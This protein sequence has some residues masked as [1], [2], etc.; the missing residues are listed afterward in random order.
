MSTYS[1]EI[2]G[3]YKLMDNRVVEHMG[4]INAGNETNIENKE[5]TKKAK[6]L[7]TKIDQSTLVKGMSEMLSSVLNEVAQQNQAEMAALIT[8]SNEME[9]SNVDLGDGVFEITDTTQT[10]EVNQTA[11]M[12]AKQK[13]ES[14]V[15]N[16]I[17]KSIDEALSKTVDK[18]KQD[19]STKD[20]KE[21]GGTNIG[22]VF[23]KDLGGKLIDGAK[24]ILSINAGNTTNTKNIKENE[25]KLKKTFNLDESFK[26][27]KDSKVE[28]A[29]KNILKKENLAKCVAKTGGKNAFRVDNLKAGGVKIKGFN[30]KAAIAQVLNC[31]FDQQALD[32]ISNLMVQSYSQLVDNMIKSSD[33]KAT[34][35]KR[36]ITS[37]D[38]YAAGVAGKQ[39]LVAGGKFAKD[40]GTGLATA[41]KG[42]GEGVGSVFSGFMKPLIII[43][44]IGAIGGIIMLVIK[45]SAKKGGRSGQSTPLLDSGSSGNDGFMD[46]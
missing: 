8:Y 9:F 18:L 41:A 44:I 40:A 32:D 30:Q 10:T 38:I 20:I 5:I 28:D 4:L 17:S 14:K 22:D 34:K 37:G 1:Y 2:D 27:E 26:I 3:S 11:N 39:I 23:G 16:S 7:D 46:E 19:T 42:I 13:S 35:E 24:D 29:I 33:L 25:E 45:M 12:E 31:A 36:D 15:M 6:E 21:A 43:A